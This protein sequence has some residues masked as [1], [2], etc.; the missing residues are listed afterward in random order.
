VRGSI[1]GRRGAVGVAWGRVGI[2]TCG[3]AVGGCG[4]DAGVFVKVG[5]A[6]ARSSVGSLVA[7]IAKIFVSAVGLCM[8]IYLSS[9]HWHPS[10]TRTNPIMKMNEKMV[11]NPNLVRIGASPLFS[12]SNHHI[13]YDEMRETCQPSDKIGGLVYYLPP[14]HFWAV[15][16]LLG[17]LFGC[18]A[19]LCQAL[20]LCP[21]IVKKIGSSR[22]SPKSY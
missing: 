2:T 11:N 17:W 4:S 10:R 13:Y 21:P 14:A 9:Y 22:H 16:S 5:M 8:G 18:F 12:L 19:A 15:F 7:V 1:T 6:I 3:V 20:N